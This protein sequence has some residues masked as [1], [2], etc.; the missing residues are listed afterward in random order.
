MTSRER[1]NDDRE[2]SAQGILKPKGI[3]LTDNIVTFLPPSK[4]SEV[5]FKIR[6]PK[7]QKYMWFRTGLGVVCWILIHG[8]MT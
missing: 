8:D 2:K 6:K 1:G 4:P 3:H 7:S 5:S